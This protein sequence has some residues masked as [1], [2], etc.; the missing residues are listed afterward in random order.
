VEEISDKRMTE[1]E[2]CAKHQPLTLDDI[3]AARILSNLASLD[4]LDLLCG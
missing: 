2:I 1:E 4:L 3:R